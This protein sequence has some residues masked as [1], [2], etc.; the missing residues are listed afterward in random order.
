MTTLRSQPLTYPPPPPLPSSSAKYLRMLSTEFTRVNARSLAHISTSRR[1]YIFFPSFPYGKI[2]EKYVSFA[3]FAEETS[4][5]G[6]YLS[7]G[8]SERER[9]RKRNHEHSRIH[10]PCDYYIPVLQKERSDLQKVRARA[11]RFCQTSPRYLRH[12]YLMLERDEEF[13]HA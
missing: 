9:E 13:I 5:R 3:I 12:R 11:C 6:F 1:R 2:R 4:P 10:I 8:K 7:R